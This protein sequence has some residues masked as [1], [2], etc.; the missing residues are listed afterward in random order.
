[1]ARRRRN[2]HDAEA[3]S[4]GDLSTAWN[5]GG[6][7]YLT[8]RISFVAKLAERRTTRILSRRYGISVAEWR[9]LAQLT[10]IGPMTVRQLAERSWVDRAEVSRAA[11]S[12]IERGHVVRADNP[13]DRRSPIFSATAEGRALAAAIRP[14]RQRFQET[15]AGQLSRADM[16]VFL[17]GLYRLALCLVDEGE[18]AAAGANGPAAPPPG[19]E[20]EAPPAQP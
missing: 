15:L 4:L 19:G 12:L 5:M 3:A 18:E 9:V 7:D 17:S 20:P 1:M 11:A 6:P 2:Q 13:R 14:T 16:D 10:G 8:L